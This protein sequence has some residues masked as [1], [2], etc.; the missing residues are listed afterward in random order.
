MSM[1][2]STP[3]LSA[4]TPG[5]GSRPIWPSERFAQRSTAR[6]RRWLSPCSWQSRVTRA[7]RT[8]GVSV[9]SYNVLERRIIQHRLSQQLLLPPVLVLEPLKPLGVGDFHPAILA[10]HL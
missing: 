9:F 6:V 1:R 7:R 8:A 3:S 10:F 5:C 2:S 4:T